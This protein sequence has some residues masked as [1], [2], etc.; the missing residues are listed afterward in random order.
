MD[1]SR[2]CSQSNEED[3]FAGIEALAPGALKGRTYINVDNEAEGELLNSSAG[4]V[5]VSRPEGPTA[6]S[7]R[8]PVAPDARSLS[9]AYSVATPG[10]TSTRNGA[11]RTSSWPGCS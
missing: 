11:A 4:G 1:R 7:R 8:H 9:M 3:G 5:H 10:S 2:S 6:R